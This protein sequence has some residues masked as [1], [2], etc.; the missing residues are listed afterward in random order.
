MVLLMTRRNSKLY[1]F[2]LMLVDALVLLIAFGAAYIIRTQVDH[3]PLLQDVYWQDYLLSALLIIPFWIA[4][5]SIVGLYQP[6]VYNRRL[7]EWSK[8]VIGVFIGIL[9]VIGWEY[10]SDRNIFPARLVAVYAL[11]GTFIL[12]VFERE[13][14]R[15]IRDLSYRFGRGIRRVLLIGSSGVTSDIA[16]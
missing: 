2:I 9:L 13:V 12:I 10:V 7:L 8:I 6:K 15:L 16:V 5:F 14:M 11:I 1:S 3:R 4:I